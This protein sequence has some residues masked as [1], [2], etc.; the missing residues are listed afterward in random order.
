MFRTRLQHE[1]ETIEQ[2]VIDFKHKAETCNNGIL[3][4]SLIR[5]QLVLGTLN[6]KVKEILLSNDNLDHYPVVKP[7]KC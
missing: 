3:E 4:E 2:F 7:A 6:L 1:G 5:E